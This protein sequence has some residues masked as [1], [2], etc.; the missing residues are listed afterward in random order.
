M[1]ATSAKVGMLA[2]L[3]ATTPI[4]IETP[5]VWLQW[6]L[7]GVVVGFTLWRDHHREKRMAS[8]IERQ[9][10]W[11]RETLLHAVEQNTAALNDITLI[12]RHNRR[13]PTD[14]GRS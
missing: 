4:G 8:A 14:D 12:I 2:L 7:A 3:G 9:E 5:D 13:L 10:A 6:G 11:V 1:T